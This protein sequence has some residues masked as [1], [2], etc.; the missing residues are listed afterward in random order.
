MTEE[1]EIMGEYD[2]AERRIAQILGVKEDK[3]LPEVDEETLMVY[4][5]YLNKEL[6]FSFEAEYSKE[7]GQLEDTWYDIKVTGFFNIEKYLDE[8]YGLFVTARKGKKKIEIPLAEVEVKEEGKNKELVD[9]Y[10]IWFWN[11]R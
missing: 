7:T 3:E 11:Y 8:F 5:Q 2:A 6:S 9:D 1:E 4:Y 10:S